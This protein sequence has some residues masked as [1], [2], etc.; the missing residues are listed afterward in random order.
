MTAKPKVVVIGLDCAPPE[1]VFDRLAHRMPFVTGLRQTGVWGPLLSTIPPI[2]VPAWTS[3]MTGLDPGQLGLYGFRN[4]TRYDYSSLA[5]ANATGVKAPRLWDILGKAALRSIVLGVPQT[6][7]PK[8]I[9]GLMVAGFLSPGPESQFTHPPEL[10]ARLPELC[11]GEYQIDVENFREKGP[12]ELKAEIWNM[13]R[14]RFALAR[15]LVQESDWD[16]FMMVEMGPD[17]LHHGFWG[18]FDPGH[19]LYEP[20]NPYEKVIPDYYGMLDREIE[21][22]AGLLPPDTLVLLVS[23][24]GAQPMQGGLAIN[25][26][27]MAKGYLKLTN[28]R[29]G[30][31]PLKPDMVDWP[32]T[33]AWGEGGYYSRIFLNVDGREPRG[34]L[35]P[36]QAEAF[37]RRLK[38]ELESMSGPD[39]KLMKNRVLVPSQVYRETRGIPPDLILYPGDL[40]WRSVAW[41]GRGQLFTTENDT[42]SD[43]ANHA[44]YGIFAAGVKGKTASGSSLVARQGE[45]SIFDVAPTV[46]GWFGLPSPHEMIG[47]DIK[48]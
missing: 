26:W 44:P 41:V 45:F 40:A 4:R 11:G 1:L 47:R 36:D 9:N 13:T 22:L 3:M 16:F 46:L 14:R 7:P 2:T 27:L 28:P 5:V 43:H 8:P 24:H 12:D 37:C 17:R 35:A 31:G 42:G 21:S 15:S 23:D 20:G 32:R 29:P 10:K 30:W 6:Y 34:A 48:L 18:Y 39:G 33:L 25:E 38:H 19:R